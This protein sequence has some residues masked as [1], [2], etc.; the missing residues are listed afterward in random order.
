MP[1]R[2]GGT[3]HVPPTMPACASHASTHNIKTERVLASLKTSSGLGGAY[4][5]NRSGGEESPVHGQNTTVN[6][7]KIR[8]FHQP[9]VWV[10]TA[11]FSIV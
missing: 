5:T 4:E 2:P 1:N 7:D 6:V 10:K 9:Y 11:F 8:D 3:G